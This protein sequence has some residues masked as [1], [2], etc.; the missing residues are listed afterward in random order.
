[1]L[2]QPFEGFLANLFCQSIE[3]SD[4]LNTKY[5]FVS[6]NPTQ[7]IKLYNGFKSLGFKEL[8][9]NNAPLK[10]VE[11][12]SG[13]KII[14][15]LHHLGVQDRNSSHED[16][17]ASVRD[18]LNDIHNAILFLINNSSLETL[19][20]TFADVSADNGIYTP[21]RINQALLDLGAGHKN[22][23][24]F[25][26]LVSNKQ[27]QIDEENLSIFGYEPLYKSIHKD[28]IDIQEYGFFPEPRIYDID[29]EKHLARELDRNIRLARTVHSLVN[30][31]GDELNELQRQLQDLGFSERYIEDKFIQNKNLYKTETFSNIE[32]EIEKNKL[33]KLN[34]KSIDINGSTLEEWKHS[35]GSA[36]ANRCISLI[37]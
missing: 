33:R 34:V 24:I 7:S 36:S 2:N 1:M 13:K 10:Y 37:R 22:E 3:L 28:H 21:K 35:S 15:M 25:N 9:I 14:V 23:L 31:F 29:N 6:S 30:D 8:F 26:Y 32:A 16:Y 20:S 19:T 12:S 17:I 11:T 18:A 4:S 27:R 5:H